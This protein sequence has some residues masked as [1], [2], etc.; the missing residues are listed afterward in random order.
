MSNWSSKL[1]IYLKNKY[2]I[3]EDN[4]QNT[5]EIIL[6]YQIIGELSELTKNYIEQFKNVEKLYMCSCKL[7]SLENLPK[8]PNLIRIQL[9]DNNLHEKEIKK[10]HSFPQLNEIYAANNI[11]E[12]FEDLEEL[13]DMR[14]LHLL[15]LSNNPICQN[16]EYREKMFKIFPRLLFLDGVGKHSETYEEFEENEEEEE[17]EEEENEDD[18]NFIDNNEENDNDESKDSEEEENEDEE[19]IND[20]EEEEEED[21]IENPNPAKK[22]KIK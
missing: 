16:K 9:N 1:L 15:D 7:Y 3:T 20:E 13:S 6:D 22:K 21:E 10:L 17:E 2:P 14:E 8:L 19:N 4:I 5:N 11:I 12:S 18:K